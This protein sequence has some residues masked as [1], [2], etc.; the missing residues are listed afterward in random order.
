MH[1]ARCAGTGGTVSSRSAVAPRWVGLLLMPVAILAWGS[2][3]AAPFAYVPNEGSATVSVID[4]ATD[5]VTQTLKIGQ[6]PRGIAVDR[7]GSRLY[8]SDQTSGTLIAYDIAK[9]TEAGR[10]E[11]GASPEAINLS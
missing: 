8:I 1:Q 2:A 10:A 9:G 4:T 7:E 5:R 11:L 3:V 6:K